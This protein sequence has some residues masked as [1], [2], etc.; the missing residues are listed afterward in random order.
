MQASL[1]KQVWSCGGWI[2]VHSE[3]S[4]RLL[5]SRL[6]AW[7]WNL[8]HQT[9][10]G[11]SLILE[12]CPWCL[13]FSFTQ[14]QEWLHY[15]GYCRVYYHIVFNNMLS[16]HYVLLGHFNN[17]VAKLCSPGQPGF[18]LLAASVVGEGSVCWGGTAKQ[19]RKKMPSSLFILVTSRHPI[20][21]SY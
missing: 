9:S 14:G 19:G 6:R 15:M 12:N 1:S 16:V 2:I 8:K 10:C 5:C 3:L 20:Q 13:F 4:D 7:H 11:E 17:S 21:V 18:P